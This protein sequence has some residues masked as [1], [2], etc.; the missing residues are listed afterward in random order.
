MKQ[1]P[2]VEGQSASA[3]P[4]RRKPPRYR[5]LAVM[6]LAVLITMILFFLVH[7]YA[8]VCREVKQARIHMD[9]TRYGP[10][11]GALLGAYYLYEIGK[12][13]PLDVAP[14]EPIR[15]TIQGRPM[16]FNP[17]A[18]SQNALALF[19]R[20]T[21]GPPTE[22]PLMRRRFIERARFLLTAQSPVA[23]GRGAVWLYHNRNPWFP[24]AAI[25]HISGI[26]QGEG[27]SVLLRAYQ[28]TGDS[29]YLEGA[30]RAYRGLLIPLEEGGAAWSKGG[31]LFFEEVP[32]LP[33]THILNGNIYALFGVLDYYRVTR[34]PE[35]GEVFSRGIATVR[36]RLPGYDQ[37]FWSRYDDRATGWSG[38]A[39]PHYMAV[40]AKQLHVLYA[41]T[42]DAVYKHYEVRWEGLLRDSW[43]PL[44]YT[45]ARQYYRARRLLDLPPHQASPV[46]EIAPVH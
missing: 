11:S 22:R 1:S 28:L 6:V 2:V 25:P 42:G 3:A 8:I 19:A 29:A 17:V 31:L 32:S 9:R 33:P 37:W 39:E 34:D 46:L 43:P 4:G 14:Q 36:E 26:A 12:E 24:F 10:V 5:R 45:L 40:H 41:L 27:I 15:L 7:Q 30:H 18:E 13:A 20:C 35:A 38:S 16:G 44:V 21:A 23:G